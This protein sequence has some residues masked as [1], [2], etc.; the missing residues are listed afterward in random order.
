M[1]TPAPGRQP[2]SRRQAGPTRRE[3]PA[4]GKGQCWRFRAHSAERAASYPAF[5]KVLPTPRPNPSL[6]PTRHKYLKKQRTLETRGVSKVYGGATRNVSSRRESNE[7]RET[8]R[9]F[10]TNCHN[11]KSLLPKGRIAEA[12]QDAFVQQ[13][14]CVRLIWLVFPA[15]LYP[16]R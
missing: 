9:L 3:W 8:P 12:G 10:V 14:R 7:H 1:T 5:P 16:L 2:P 11:C 15:A 6:M 13:E 4:T